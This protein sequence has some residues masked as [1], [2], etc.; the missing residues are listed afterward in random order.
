[1]KIYVILTVTKDYNIWKDY[2]ITCKV[3]STTVF[4]EMARLGILSS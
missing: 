4:T 1:M 3:L 2:N